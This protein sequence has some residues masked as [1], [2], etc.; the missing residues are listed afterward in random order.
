MTI[1]R[2]IRE[3]RE[4][5]GW[6][7]CQLAEASLVSQQHI[8]KLE[9]EHSNPRMKTVSKIFTAMGIQLGISEDGKI[10]IIVV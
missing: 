7:Q 8:A 6:S 5:K 10:H 9:K 2:A 1:G 3:V 4:R